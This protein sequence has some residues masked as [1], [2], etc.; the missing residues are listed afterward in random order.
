VLG[1]PQDIHAMMT[2]YDTG[3]DEQCVITMKFDNGA[4][5]VLSS[6]FAV[7]T[8]V[9]AMIAGTQGRIKM[10][11]RFHNPSGEVELIVNNAVKKIEVLKEEGYGYQ[12]EARHVG[13]CLR[14]GLTESPVMSHE[15]SLL[16][17]ETLDQIR[18]TCGI[19]YAA[20]KS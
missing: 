11:N 13:E 20:D 2:P 10:G 6:T 7:D 9:E 5:A 15:D 12:F 16:L 14:K 3:V 4:L 8:P 1:K 19:R 18:S 17:M